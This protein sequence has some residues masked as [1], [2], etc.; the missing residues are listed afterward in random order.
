MISEVLC[1]SPHKAK[2]DSIF[3]ELEGSDFKPDILKLKGDHYLLGYF[4]S[5]KYFDP[6]R[7]ILLEEYTPRQAI[8]PQGQKILKKIEST[9]SVSIHIRRGDYVNV[10]E[11]YK[12]IEGIIT[13]R[14]YQNAVDYIAAKIDNPHFLVFSN[15]MAWVKENFRIP[16]QIT[17]VDFNAAQSGY[18]DLWLMSRCKH[19]ITAGGST[20]SW[21]AA[22]LNPYKEKII[23]RTEQVSNEAKY[24]HPDDY[25]LPEWN[26]VNS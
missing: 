5:Y 3:R 26:A 22:Y 24:N 18:E 17:Y 2:T 16:H 8:S 25:F 13:D 6:I 20:F 19:N 15:D 1:R 9:N 21:W 23:V 7:N 4:N 10:P 11:V 14:F 12:C